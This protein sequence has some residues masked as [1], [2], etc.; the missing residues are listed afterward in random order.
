LSSFNLFK[1]FEKLTSQSALFS[2]GAKG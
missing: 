2:I 1:E